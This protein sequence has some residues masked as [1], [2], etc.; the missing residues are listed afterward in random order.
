MPIVTLSTDLGLQDPYVGIIKG[1]IL[2]RCPDVH[3]ID[4]T[5]NINPFDIV[6]AAWVLRQSFREFPEDSIHLVNVNNANRF[7]DYFILFREKG[8][9]FVGPDNGLFSLTF[10]EPIEKAYS[11]P[12]DEPDRF[13]L[14]TC[15]AR[16]VAHIAAGKPLNEIG[17]PV[18]EPESR[19]SLHP[20]TSRTGIQGHVVHVDHY[21]NAILN[22][23]QTLFERIAEERDFALYFK[24]HEPLRRICSYYADV[25]I[26]EPLCWFNSGG[27]LEIAVNMGRAAELLGLKRENPVQ[28][29]FFD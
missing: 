17:P 15:F 24:T 22:I 14:K 27:F 12:C 5:H 29:D 3:L 2:K 21:G 6:Q 7:P 13:P 1:A 26:G 19:I 4:I 11:I 9:Y 28:I 8:H 18:A 16:A 23:H 20:V 25:A 10:E